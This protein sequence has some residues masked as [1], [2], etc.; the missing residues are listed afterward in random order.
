MNTKQNYTIYSDSTTHSILPR[1]CADD[2]FTLTARVHLVYFPTG[3]TEGKHK[4]NTNTT[5]TV[6]RVNKKNSNLG[7]TSQL[8]HF[9]SIT[10][11]ERSA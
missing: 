10:S 1:L 7:S 9:I 11:N 5:H 3:N 6:A 2:G 4:K 8:V